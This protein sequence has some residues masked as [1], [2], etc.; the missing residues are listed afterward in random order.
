MKIV[1][2][3]RVTYW[4]DLIHLSYFSLIKFGWEFIHEPGIMIMLMVCDYRVCVI[5]YK[6]NIVMI[7]DAYFTTSYTICQNHILTLC[8]NDIFYLGFGWK[9]NVRV[10]KST[11]KYRSILVGQLISFHVVKQ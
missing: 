11:Q 4:L 9:K 2:C 1:L 5:F 3:S 6:I 10:T 7:K 8:S